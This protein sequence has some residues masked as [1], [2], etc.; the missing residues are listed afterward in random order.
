MLKPNKTRILGG[1]SKDPTLPLTRTGSYITATKDT[2]SKQ[3]DKK[4]GNTGA[5]SPD[6]NIITARLRQEG[7]LPSFLPVE[8]SGASDSV[9]PNKKTS[10]ASTP[11]PTSSGT[12][13]LPSKSK[14]ELFRQ[15]ISDVYD[16]QSD[17]SA[18]SGT[19]PKRGALTPLPKK[20]LLGTKQSDPKASQIV[21]KT[22]GGS[23]LTQTPEIAQL[24]ELIAKLPSGFPIAE[25]DNMTSQQRLLAVRSSGLSQQEQWKLLN[26]SGSLS[27][28]AAIQD[29]QSNSRTY[30]LTPE[31]A[32]TISAGLLKIDSAR[33][34]VK[35]GGMPFATDM[36]RS[37]FLS[38]LDKEEQKL[39]DSVDGQKEGDRDKLGDK[40]QLHSSDESRK[41]PIPKTIFNI[42]NKSE[43]ALLAKDILKGYIG[44]KYMLPTTLAMMSLEGLC[45]LIDHGTISLGLTGNA[46]ILGV[47]GPTGSVGLI[48][49]TSG[50]VGLITT[51]GG[52]AGTPQA[53]ISA[54]ASISNSDNIEDL[55]GTVVEVGGSAGEFVS[56]GGEVATVV[57]KDNKL[58]VAV[59]LNVGVGI[60]IP[61]DIHAGLSTSEVERLF[62]IFDAWAEFMEGYNEW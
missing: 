50:D 20:P 55:V 51:Y 43:L 13:S 9:T 30:G 44:L 18:P 29:I 49:D 19:V 7:L 38:Q 22:S 47:G 26:A 11:A 3:S 27:T 4:T 21:S 23:I 15:Y 60:S 58:S 12:I 62:N 53:N 6:D 39:L 25:W 41:T 40:E 45:K 34:S 16:G 17:S 56:V 42:D 57:S 32:D 48:M 5:D 35:N 24:S 46:S 54:F 28:I 8:K 31:K 52:Y 36:Q 10:P 14:L 1:Y 61:V 33:T 37:L 59:N 2:G